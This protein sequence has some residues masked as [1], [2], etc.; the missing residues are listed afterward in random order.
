MPES[1][2]THPDFSS[3]TITMSSISTGT[4][5]IV[6]ESGV[7]I[8][9][10]ST[11]T[12]TA[13]SPTYST[14]SYTQV[15][16]SNFE[17]T[18]ASV[19]GDGALITAAGEEC[20]DNNASSGDGWS[21]SCKIEN[22]Y[23]C[24]QSSTT[25]I[26][27]CS[28]LWGNGHIDS[29]EEWDDKNLSN[30][31]G[32]SSSCLVENGYECNQSSTSSPSVW[33]KVWGNGKIN[34]SE[35]WD[36]GNLI[37]TDGWND[38]CQVEAGYAWTLLSSKGNMSYC[39]RI[40]GNAKIDTGE[41]WDDGN[42]NLGDGC[43]AQWGLESGYKWDNFYDKPSFWYPIWGDGKR[44]GAPYNEEWDD[45]N[46]IDLDG[47]DGAWKVEKNYLWLNS[48]GIDVWVTTYSPPVIKS[49]SFDSKTLQITIEFDQVMKNQNLTD[50][51]MSI[52]ISGPNSP[53]DISWSAK[54]DK[55]NLIISFG[56]TPVLLGGLGEIIRLQLIDVKKFNSE[57]DISMLASSLFT[58]E[59]SGL[60]PSDSAKSGGSSAS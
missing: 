19:W 11:F 30:G 38:T 41:Q 33:T 4:N 42:Y 15:S 23:A 1:F 58:F 26:S 8:G 40:C 36:D 24:S 47:C 22:G 31:D 20:D 35:Q 14:S 32:W 56:S 25:S 49:N 50:F 29:S 7:T 48:S 13:N 54:F 45:G 59:V 27:V 39:S 34:S 6:S 60:P 55:N 28:R 37:N 52:D 57:H 43:N 18:I 5:P 2:S 46:N 17:Q 3:S 21:S 44:D 9:S 16:S 12:F 10:A 51:D 53:Y